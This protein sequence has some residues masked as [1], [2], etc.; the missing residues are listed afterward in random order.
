MKPFSVCIVFQGGDAH[1][2]RGLV[3][4]SIRVSYDMCVVGNQVG[5]HGIIV[6]LNNR[7]HARLEHARQFIYT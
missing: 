4:C 1:D 6:K 3:V 7:V 2:H 5:L